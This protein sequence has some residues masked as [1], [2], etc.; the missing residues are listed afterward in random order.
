VFGQRHDASG[1]RRGAEF[2]VNTST[3]WHQYLANAAT[4]ASGNFLVAWTGWNATV[5][6]RE[7]FV[8]RFAASGDGGPEVRANTF[9][10]QAQNLPDVVATANGN[11]VVAWGSDTQDLSHYGVFAQRFST[12]PI[13]RDGFE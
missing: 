6:S 9:T 4:D 8:R 1:N 12:D 11:F 7:I 2:R 10:T 3:A 5:T 13:F